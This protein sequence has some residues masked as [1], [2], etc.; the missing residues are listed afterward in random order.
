MQDLDARKKKFRTIIIVYPFALIG[1]AAIIN[2][3]AFGVT[4]I[5]PALPSE[6][7]VTAAIISAVILLA[8]HSWLMTRTELTRLRYDLYSTP[9]EWAARG[10]DPKKASQFGLSELARHHNAHRNMTE[11]TVHFAVLAGL[12]SIVSPSQWAAELWFL[13][14][15]LGRLAHGFCFVTGNDGARGIAMSV[16]L[17]SLYGM[18]T[19]LLLALFA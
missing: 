3:I 17:M 5:S 7:V 13:G 19:Y 12:L 6:S 15:A 14:F 10:R 2:T 11:N 8:T 18:A 9:E 1:I 4:P 16:S